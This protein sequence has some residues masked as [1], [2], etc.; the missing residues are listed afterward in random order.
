MVSKG[1]WLNLG[2]WF[3]CSGNL[4]KMFIKLRKF[5]IEAIY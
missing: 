2:N 4:G 3:L 5:I 1:Y